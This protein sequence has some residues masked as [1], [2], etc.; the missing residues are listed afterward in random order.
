MSVIHLFKIMK[1]WNR[2]LTGYRVIG[3]GCLIEKGLERSLS[4]PNCSKDSWKLLSL[5]I[6]ILLIYLTHHDVTDLVNYRMVKNTKP[7][8]SWERNIT[9]L[10]NKKINNPCLKWHILRSHRFVA[11]VAFKSNFKQQFWKADGKKNLNQRQ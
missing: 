8:M 11:E 3:A 2:Y 9:F 10:R 7:W 6:L 1:H 4:P 5:L